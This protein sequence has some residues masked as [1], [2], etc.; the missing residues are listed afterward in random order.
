MMREAHKA[1]L[2]LLTLLAVGLIAAHAIAWSKSAP[3]GVRVHD[4]EF[5]RVSVKS[6]DC[7][8]T[9]KVRFKAPPKAYKS[10]AKVRNVYYF[11]ARVDLKNGRQLETPVFRSSSPAR[12]AFT[13]T[14]NTS[15][16][17]CWAKEKSAIINLDVVGCRGKRCKVPE[18]E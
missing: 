13:H 17:G 10:R 2:S 14:V 18:F 7:E 5:H 11:K 1:C 12:R 3:T 8:L 9:A 16:D 15:A 6:N 4:H